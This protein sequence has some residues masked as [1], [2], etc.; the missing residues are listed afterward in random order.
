MIKQRFQMALLAS[1]TIGLAP[2][3]P[4]PH[5]FGK[6]RWIMGG[7]QGMA[8]MDYFDLVMHGL[9]WL[10][11][12]YYALILLIKSKS[13]NDMKIQEI[14]TQEGVQII[15]VRE[16]YEFGAGHVDGAVNMPLSQLSTSIHKIKK[17]KGPKVLYCRSGARSARAMA[18]LE[19]KGIEQ[20]YN[21]G[22][23]HQMQESMRQIQ[24]QIKQ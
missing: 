13:P 21:G 10:F 23:L 22:G 20:V 4:E 16:T 14:L 18:F 6:V 19:S 3:Y 5:L 12:A 7:A 1:L 17:M 15:D 8:A 2:F 9:P 24:H 11:L